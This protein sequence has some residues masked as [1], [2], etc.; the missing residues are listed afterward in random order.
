MIQRTMEKE[1][2]HSE[3]QFV[4]NNAKRTSPVMGPEVEQRGRL[5][6]LF[7][8]AIFKRWLFPNIT[9]AHQTRRQR[10]N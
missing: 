10:T 3:S 1:E 5:S 6:Y 9:I 8:N 4:L 2:T 7:K